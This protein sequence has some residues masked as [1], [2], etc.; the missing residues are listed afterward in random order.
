MIAFGPCTPFSP[1][2]TRPRFS[3][4]SLLRRAL[5]AAAVVAAVLLAGSALAGRHVACFQGPSENVWWWESELDTLWVLCSMDEP[6]S[7]R[8]IHPLTPPPPQ[9]QNPWAWRPAPISG[10]AQVKDPLGAIKFYIPRAGGNGGWGLDP[11]S[12]PAG[13]NYYDANGNW[14]AWLPCGRTI[15]S[16]GSG[17]ADREAQFVGFS[18]DPSGLVTT[19]VWKK[20]SAPGVRVENT[21]KVPLHYVAVGGG[22]VAQAYESRYAQAP[23]SI[24]RGAK[25]IASTPDDSEV[26]ASGRPTMRHWRGATMGNWAAEV[27][28]N[29]VFVIGLTQNY[30]TSTRTPSLYD[31]VRRVS[32]WAPGMAHWPVASATAPAGQ[33]VLS[34]GVEAV[35]QFFDPSGTWGQYVTAIAPVPGPCKLVPDC[36]RYNTWAAE[37]K[38]HMI[39]AQGWV[40][41][42]LTTVPAQVLGPGPG[43]SA[44]TLRVLQSAVTATTP[45]ESAVPMLNLGGL[46]GVAALTGIGAVATWKHY[47]RAGNQV[48]PGSLLWK[49]EPTVGGAALGSAEHMLLSPAALLGYAVGIR[50]AP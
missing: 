44:P 26:D 40:R 6:G 10:I 45:G 32:A 35:S 21:V 37:S 31:Q 23:S 18:T 34:A 2:R 15:T 14:I 30:A 3:V 20:T 43:E 29:T 28:T 25:I 46:H 12:Q 13:A 19:A 5:R 38:D 11:S 16:D 22:V 42:T 36:N 24:W 50:L 7:C 27:H 1:F 4:G 9:F 8:A 47:D 41:V 17:P 39:S 49:L 33:V 48:S